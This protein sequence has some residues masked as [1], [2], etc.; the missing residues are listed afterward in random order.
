MKTIKEIMTPQ[1]QVV[2]PE[3][4]IMEVAQVM[5]QHD[6]GAVPVC[7][8]D[9]LVG[10]VTDRDLVLRC[11]AKGIDPSQLTAE[12]VMSEGIIFCFE[13]Q[14]VGEAARIMEVRK[15]RRLVVLNADRRMCGIVTVGDIATRFGS[16]ELTG[17]IL[18][19]VSEHT[20]V[21]T[22]SPSPSAVA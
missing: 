21:A 9:R 17:E 5:K 6:V 2:S 1:V 11:L 19:R 22:E 14:D 3:T 15:V 13:T 16:E 8:N 18:E 4:P 7:G 12:K 10:M 20:P